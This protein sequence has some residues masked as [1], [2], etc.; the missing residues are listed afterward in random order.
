MNKKTFHY[1]TDKIVNVLANHFPQKRFDFSSKIYLADLYED[2]LFI[3]ENI[4]GQDLRVLD[5]GCGKGHL[6]AL[7]SKSLQNQVDAV[8]LEKSFGE[9]GE[10][11]VES[12]G[13][14]WQ[15]NIW[16]EFQTNYPVNYQFYD[17]RK[18]PYNENTFNVL[19]AYAV[20]EH[21]EDENFFLK[22]CA[23]V[24]KN[25]GKLFIFRC[26]SKLSLTENLAKILKLPHHDRLYN[27]KTLKQHF[28]LNNFRVINIKKYDSFPA[29][30]PLK[31]FQNIWNKMFILNNIFRN[32]FKIFPFKIFAHHFRLIAIINK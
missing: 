22:E 19:V 23:R 20:I 11:N 3:K 17:G 5:I 29:F 12:L 9:G 10:F 6:S 7:L 14:H 24:L 32:I 31:K 26:P 27:K 13:S 16:Q 21:V 15:A 25:K 30:T 8:D 1:E 28:M 2:L 18:L 4:T